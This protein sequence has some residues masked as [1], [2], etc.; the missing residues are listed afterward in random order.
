MEG[1]GGEVSLIE[2]PAENWAK[3]R[4]AAAVWTRKAPENPWCTIANEHQDYFMYWLDRHQFHPWGWN[5]RWLYDYWQTN[6][7]EPPPEEEPWSP[8]S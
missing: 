7:V 6:P 4:D 1:V 5:V 2:T 3:H 8:Q